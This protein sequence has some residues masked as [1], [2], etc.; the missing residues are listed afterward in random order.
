MDLLPRAPS[1]VL[2]REV[3]GPNSAAYSRIIV[4]IEGGITVVG[5]EVDGIL[6]SLPRE[7]ANSLFV[8]KTGY[9]HE[10]LVF[11]KKIVNT[12]VHTHRNLKKIVSSYF[13]DIIPY[14]HTIIIIVYIVHVKL[15]E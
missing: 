10:I 5:E 11:E 3:T 13:F 7:C 14:Y 8:V 6:S 15:I 4:I 2:P 1:S 12:F 9:S